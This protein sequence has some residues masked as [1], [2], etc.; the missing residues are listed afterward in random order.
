MKQWLGPVEDLHDAE[1]IVDRPCPWRQVRCSRMVCRRD[2]ALVVQS[3]KMWHLTSRT[4]TAVW[5]HILSVNLYICYMWLHVIG[6]WNEYTNGGSYFSYTWFKGSRAKWSTSAQEQCVV[7]MNT[8]KPENSDYCSTGWAGLLTATGWVCLHL[9]LTTILRCTTHLE[10]TRGPGSRRSTH[11]LSIPACFKE[12]HLKLCFRD[13][14]L[15]VGQEAAEVSGHTLK[16]C[17]CRCLAVFTEWGLASLLLL[18]L[19]YMLASS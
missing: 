16:R 4:Q 8:C 17:S 1:Q 6:W 10:G 9:D 5:H 12:K 13:F 18:L 3:L 11:H 2:E 19:Q 7:H 14:I 15:C